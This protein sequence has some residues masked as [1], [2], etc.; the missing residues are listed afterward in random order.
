[1]A[2]LSYPVVM[3]ENQT[4]ANRYCQPGGMIIHPWFDQALTI[5]KEML[6][7]KL[8]ALSAFCV[9]L[10]SSYSYAG[11]GRV[12]YRMPDAGSEHA[13]T[14]TKP[15]VYK[16]VN[17]GVTSFSDIPPSKGSFVVW[18]VSCYACN[19]SSNIDWNSTKLHLQEFSDA[20]K[21]ATEKYEVD[22]A[23]VRAVIHAESGFNALARSR[24]GAM[25]LMQLMP[26][27]AREVGVSDARVPAHNIRGGVQYL[28]GLLARFRGNT[29]LATA[30]YN[31]G[32][33]AVE[34]YGGVP[35]YAE[36][37]AY[38]QRVEILRRRY[39]NSDG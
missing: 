17:A 34:K 22:P 10:F 5:F 19:L 24:K 3:P 6:P 2:P 13:S 30:A 20:I 8:R 18:S 35:P 21:F 28:A 33:E 12:D 31:A 23:L 15:K 27:T 25:G 36:T 14:Q 1:M 9:L 4:L 37:Q 29:T 38:V 32:P 7:L 16:Y 11:N 26:G 39:K